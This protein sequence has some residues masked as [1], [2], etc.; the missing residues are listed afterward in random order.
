MNPFSFN[1]LHRLLDNFFFLLASVYVE[2]IE[3][4]VSIHLLSGPAAPIQIVE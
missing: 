4:S 2:V 3:C 1:S